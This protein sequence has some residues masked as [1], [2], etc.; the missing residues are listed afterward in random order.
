MRPA[1]HM[2]RN[3][4]L[5]P[6]RTGVYS[7][8]NAMRLILAVLVLIL[9]LWAIGS[10]LGSR[11]RASRKLLWTLGIVLV[12]LAGALAWFAVRAGSARR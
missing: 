5:R 9:D 1:R 12:P 4:P 7:E 2:A 6:A 10:V 8:N 11:L 3:L